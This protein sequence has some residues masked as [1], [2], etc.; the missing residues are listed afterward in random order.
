MTR[1]ELKAH[2][3]KGTAP[4]Y[5][6][7]GGKVYDVSKSQ[8]WP[9]GT[10]MAR[11]QAGDDLTDVLRLAPHGEEMLA[12]LSAV[13]ELEAGD[14]AADPSRARMQKLYRHFHPHPLTIHFPIAGYFFAA[15]MLTIYIVFKA[16]SFEAA[17]FYALVFSTLAAPPAVG[18]GIF[19]W[20]LNYHMA[21]TP[22]FRNKLVFSNGAMALGLVAIGI[23][24]LKPDAVLAGGGMFGLYAALVFAI[25]PMVFFVA[26]NGGK[27]TWPD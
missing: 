27:L 20:W 24:G 26:F 10:H 16:P 25:V 5:I 15:L 8:R 22:I 21:L 14:A 12:R 6:A 9:G 11:H 2:D 18:A 3:G 17:A 23:R 4:A 19:S 1:E 13:G 7:Y